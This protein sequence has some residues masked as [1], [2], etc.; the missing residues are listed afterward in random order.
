MN[1]P[2]TGGAGYMGSRHHRAGQRLAIRLLSSTIFPIARLSRSV[3]SVAIVG[4]DI[5]LYEG[6]VANHA[7]LSR[8]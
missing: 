6:D 8:V 4:H 7:E 5:T 3:E 1:V 2:L